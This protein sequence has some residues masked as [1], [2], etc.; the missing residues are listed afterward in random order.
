MLAGRLLIM[1]LMLGMINNRGMVVMT[2]VFVTT[3]QS[4]LEASWKLQWLMSE[5]MKL[6]LIYVWFLYPIGR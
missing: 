2:P 5:D 1:E 6:I 3:D 4:L